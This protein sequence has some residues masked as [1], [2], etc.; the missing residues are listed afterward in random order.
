MSESEDPSDSPKYSDPVYEVVLVHDDGTEEWVPCLDAKELDDGR[1]A[2][3]VLL[4]NVIFRKPGRWRKMP[5]ANFLVIRPE[6]RALLARGNVTPAEVEELR[7]NS[8]EWEALV[9]VMNNEALIGRMEHAFENCS[10]VGKPA[11][12]Y[13]DAVVGVFAPE[14]LR[15]FKFAA[16]EAQT[17]SEVVDNIREA[18]GQK[19]THY[20]VIADDVKELVEAIES[21]CD[22]LLVLK[23]IR[24]E[25][26]RTDRCQACKIET[27]IG[28]EENPHPVPEKFHVCSLARSP[29]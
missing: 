6:I 18:L 22:P 24:K 19:V 29:L 12:S 4:G 3:E 25:G 16:Q 2:A 7:C 11:S 8:Y 15:R 20:L 17:F 23:R 10:H 27:E 14:L 5:L 21:R 1:L 9:P 26:A 28:T 13:N